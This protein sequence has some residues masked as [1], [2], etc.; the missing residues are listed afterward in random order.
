MQI[1]I[2]DLCPAC[3]NGVCDNNGN[4]VCNFGYTGVNCDT[5][6]FYNRKD[7]V[8]HVLQE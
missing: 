7:S 1:N 2:T 6:K 8:I 5:S 3:L 4:C